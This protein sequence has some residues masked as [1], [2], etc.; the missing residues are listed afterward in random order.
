LTVQKG[1][2]ASSGLQRALNYAID[3]AVRNLMTDREFI[4]ALLSTGKPAAVVQ[5]VPT[6]PTPVPS[7]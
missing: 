6:S 4:D 5:S 1:E 3:D 2:T 7:P